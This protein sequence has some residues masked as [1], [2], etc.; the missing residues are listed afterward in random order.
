MLETLRRISKGWIMK[1]ILGLLALTFVL[2]YQFSFAQIKTGNCTSNYAKFCE[3]NSSKKDYDI[4]EEDWLT[5]DF[6][7][8]DNYYTITI[9]GETE[10]IWWTY[11][12]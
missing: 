12:V 10:K 9:E 8:S 4:E 6:Y 1:I 7:F 11:L 2:F 5:V 3:W